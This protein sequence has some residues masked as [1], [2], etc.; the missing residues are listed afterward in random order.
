M[1]AIGN[2]KLNRVLNPRIVFTSHI[3]NI[4]LYAFL[5][6]ELGGIGRFQITG[7]NTLRYIIGDVEGIKFIINLIHGKLRTPK[8]QRFNKLIE[9]MNTKYSLN[10]AE[11]LLD[12]SDLA[13]NSWF[14]GFTEADGH[15]GVKVIEAKP[16]SETRKRSVSESVSIFFRLDQRSYDNPTAS[17]MLPIMEKIAQFLGASNFWTYTINNP[18]SK[19]T[20]EMLS[21]S[22]T[23]LEKFRPIVDY[24]NKYPLLG[25]KGLDFKDW[26]KFLIWLFLK[27]ILLR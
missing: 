4:G 8:N 27:N 1:P 6:F 5:Q 19:S 18:K 13:D 17:S 2:T 14:A 12:K 24:F 9:F 10:I 16:K 20:T 22:I 21:V 11:S 3:N 7:N 23:S 25:V 15:F 26:E